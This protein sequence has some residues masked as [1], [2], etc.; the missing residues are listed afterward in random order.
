MV[1]EKVWLEPGQKKLVELTIDPAAS[2][3]PLSIWDT[4]RRQ[5]TVTDGEYQV[6]VGDSSTNIVL[7]DSITVR[8]PPGR[9]Q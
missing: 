4:G 5:W 8:T 3:H 7:S 2:N 1:F 6:Y 9:Q